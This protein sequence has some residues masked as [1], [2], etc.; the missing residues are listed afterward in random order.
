MTGIVQ[1]AGLMR[2]PERLCMMNHGKFLENYCQKF[3]NI[4]CRI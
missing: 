2:P 4:F 1:I 3:R